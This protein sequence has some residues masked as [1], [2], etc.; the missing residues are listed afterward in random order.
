[1]TNQPPTDEWRKVAYHEFNDDTEMMATEI[2]QL[3]AAIE[4]RDGEIWKLRN[5][6]D[7]DD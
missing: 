1:M 7:D 3:R 5:E 2:V 4:E 6:G